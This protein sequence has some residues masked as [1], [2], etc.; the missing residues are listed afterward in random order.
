MAHDWQKDR[1]I[2]NG[3]HQSEQLHVP[4][5][6]WCCTIK[7]L[8]CLSLNKQMFGR[9][10][11]HCLPLYWNYPPSDTRH[12]PKICESKPANSKLSTH[13]ILEWKNCWENKLFYILWTSKLKKYVPVGIADLT[14]QPW[15]L[16]YSI[17]FLYHSPPIENLSKPAPLHLQFWHCTTVLNFSCWF[18]CQVWNDGKNVDL[19]LMRVS[20]YHTNLYYRSS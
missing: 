9:E 6:S 2:T 19:D 13:H 1:R 7:R 20:Q 15:S 8:L 4:R 3:A 18:L 17:H 11:T 16:W 14:L 10:G 12:P 5:C